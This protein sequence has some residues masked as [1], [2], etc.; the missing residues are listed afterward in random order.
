MPTAKQTARKNILFGV[1]MIGAGVWLT[2]E[3]LSA[4]RTGEAI[5]SLRSTL[6]WFEAIPLGGCSILIG[7]YFAAE[8]FGWI[9]PRGGPTNGV[10]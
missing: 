6:Q 8:G 1:V 5:Q 10:G 9:K 2:V 4:Y 7:A 3:G